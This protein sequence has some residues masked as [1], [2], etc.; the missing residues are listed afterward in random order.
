MR[1][2]RG[3]CGAGRR[4]GWSLRGLLGVSL[5]LTAGLS[6]QESETTP[7]DESDDNVFE[8]SVFEVN[9]SEDVGYRAGAQ[10]SMTS[11]NELIRDTPANITVVTRELIDDLQA[12][13]FKE[14]LEYESGIFM[15]T[16]ENTTSV[17]SDFRSGEVSPSSNVDVGNPFANAI[18]I[19]GYK[20]P[21][22]QRNGFRIGA[23]LPAYKVNLGGLT[24]TANTERQEVIRGPQSLLYGINVLSGI[25]NIVPQRPLSE[26]ATRVSFGMGSEDYRRF[27][28]DTTGPL[29]EGD[30]LNYR[31][32]GAYT[33]QGDWT[34]FQI[35]K[36]EY[37]AGQ[38][39]WRPFERAELLVEL[40]YG[41]FKREG[42]GPQFF[43]DDGTT[44]NRD[45]HN[46][47]GEVFTYGYDY[48]DQIKLTDDRLQG[49][50][51]VVLTERGILLEGEIYG[52]SVLVRKPGETYDFET[53]GP[54]FRISGPDVRFTSEEFDAMVL[55]RHELI[56]DLNL[57]FGAYYTK[58][59]NEEFSVELK[60]FVQGLGYVVPSSSLTASFLD[61]EIDLTDN[62]GY[63]PGELFV[64]L[65]TDQDAVKLQT[66]NRYAAYWWYKTPT[67]SET[68]QTRL[69]LT[70]SFDT[71][72]WN[73]RIRVRHSILVGG[74]FIRDD[75]SFVETD[76]LDFGGRYAYW[77]GNPG[78][79]GSFPNSRQSEDPF[80]FRSSIFDTSI[81]R[82]NGEALVTPGNFRR[83]QLVTDPAYILQSGHREATQWF[84]G[85]YAIYHG[86]FWDDRLTVI[87][88]LRHDAYQVREKE[89][90]FIA[91]PNLETGYWLRK[92]GASPTPFSLGFGDRD[93]DE[94]HWYSELS[95]D[96]NRRVQ[97]EWDELREAMPNGLTEYNFDKT[98]KYSTKLGSFSWRVT[99]NFSLFYLYSEG[100]FPNTGQR[101][102]MNQAIP[103]EETE[104]QEIGIK[105]EMLDQRIVGTLSAY[106]IHRNNAVWYW[107]N[108]PNP[109]T[110]FGGP[111]GADTEETSAFSPAAVAEGRASIK[112][113]VA[114]QYVH[115][116][117]KDAGM[118]PNYDDYYT[119]AL[120]G[121]GVSQII[122]TNSGDPT[123]GQSR[124]AY[125]V[126]DY[127][128]MKEADAN[129]SGGNP[130]RQALDNA[131]VNS[132]G[133]LGRSMNWGNSGIASDSYVHAASADN[134][135]GANVP[136]EEEGV[137]FDAQVILTPFE[138]G[139][140]QIILGY[141]H[142]EREVVGA[143]FKLA[144]GY[145][146]DA[147][148]DRILDPVSGE[149]LLMTTE[150]DYWVG[151]LG[152][153]NFADPRNPS[154]LLPGSSISGLDLSFVPRD[155]WRFWN[156]YT[157]DEGPLEGISLG[158]G[159]RYNSSIPTTIS[160][161]GENL[162]VNKFPT[163]DLP[164]RYVVDASISYR[165]KMW[166]ARW[167]LALKI[168]NVFD[169]FK[170]E[171]VSVY[172]D[173]SFREP[174]VR[175]SLAYYDPRSF[176]I[177][178][179]TEF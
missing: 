161:G 174:V 44:D 30:I 114:A 20:V 39:L 19:R 74:N 104:S 143:G 27:S 102:G 110:W 129:M 42:G 167:R 147:F 109:S 96:F 69:R 55:Y 53:K 127:E 118:D 13:D 47:Y 24:D 150:Y 2:R 88:G 9:A 105:F 1:L 89:E 64:Y 157:F 122:E 79:D 151:L 144:D 139:N 113:T 78:A 162:S 148:G 168:N 63:G 112:Y 124:Y 163:P 119:R 25:V 21:N 107:E 17:N 68:L 52:R 134:T 90:L 67:T 33:E 83:N 75:V 28:F 45:F 66:E 146:I 135:R 6:A 54:G 23:M 156:N 34:Q 26:R 41:S 57:E 40:Q 15:D 10:V 125:Y 29:K 116:A 56:D 12:V 100:I 59:D 71:N 46:A 173:E 36:T 92:E 141:S 169:D 80:Q 16:F 72:F 58:L 152:R 115:E 101:D 73:D 85:A 82:Y 22:Q 99:D 5:I 43:V 140:Y 61:P 94:D 176:R 177:M 136:F 108:A 131:Q 170:S 50:E 138:G 160:I 130:L 178:L 77:D 37:A 84:R 7:E 126:V 175:R 62:Y 31:L 159:V 87:A 11:M 155:S 165:W 35:D 4:P 98:Q 70:Y 132:L 51:D 60:T 49:M 158:G 38:L 95:D 86:K 65:P 137:G 32:I 76:S 18:S 149:P 128:A 164:E 3:L 8:L 145:A 103:A 121:L 166:D 111:Y 133:L 48:V 142:Q 93:Y 153:E 91:D 97:A 172:D 123:E 154:T 106:K 14:A 120:A 81:I 179:S 117:L 171:A